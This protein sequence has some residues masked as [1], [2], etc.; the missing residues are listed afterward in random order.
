[1]A[2]TRFKQTIIAAAVLL[3]VAALGTGSFAGSVLAQSTPVASLCALVSGTPATPEAEPSPR[4]AH[5]VHAEI[6]FDLVFIDMMIPHHESAVVMAQ[7]ALE[8]AEHDEI[9][10]LAAA[11]IAAQTAEI[12]QLEAWRAEWYPGAER[13]PMDE[14]TA[15]IA[16]R[17]GQMLDM[18]GMGHVDLMSG[19]DASSSLVSLCSAPEPFDLA[20]IDAMI[21][22]HESAVAAANVG[23]ENNTHPELR[24]LE[25]Q[26]IDGQQAEIDQMRTWRDL[27]YG[28]TPA[29]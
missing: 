19:M 6:E 21:P 2:S 1:M 7:V 28:A 24:D 3:A 12:A 18:E 15:I 4:S 16:E 22:H 20:F 10:N 29:A 27:W 11:I 23:L 8:R 9:R 25:L 5:D 13:L 17:S 26:I 14:L